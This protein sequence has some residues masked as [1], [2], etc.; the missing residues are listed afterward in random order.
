MHSVWC[1]IAAYYQNCFDNKILLLKRK[2]KTEK[3]SV[4]IMQDTYILWHTEKE[5]FNILIKKT[6]TQHV[7]VPLNLII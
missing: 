4:I 1:A 6:P 2:K 5:C 7:R 3:P